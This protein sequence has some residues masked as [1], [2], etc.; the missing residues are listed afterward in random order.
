M[1]TRKQNGNNKRTEIER[2]DWPFEWKQTRVAFGW[3]S[4]R[5]GKKKLHALELSRIQVILRFDVILQHDWPME[6][7][8][9]HVRVFFGGKRRGHVLIFSSIG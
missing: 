6:Q 3:L 2:F 7:C 1:K 4:E 5:S 9:L 8:L